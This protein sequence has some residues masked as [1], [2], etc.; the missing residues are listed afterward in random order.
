MWP[1]V[2]ETT[3]AENVSD[4]AI[5][6]IVRKK[7][8]VLDFGF[9]QHVV[10]WLS[11]LLRNAPAQTLPEDVGRRADQ[12]M[13]RERT[14]LLEAL[15]DKDRQV[16]VADSFQGLPQPDRESYPADAGDRLWTF[17]TLA[18]PLGI[19]RWK[20]ERYGLLDSRRQ[21]LA[22]VVSRH[23]PVRCRRAAG[24]APSRWRPV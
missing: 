3:V 14:F 2:F 5:A 23:A 6:V 8:S 11:A 13:I 18:V 19:V 4:C 15:G 9:P 16:W 7:V 21:I 12:F 22:R 10:E 20:F 17:D 24:S 1:S